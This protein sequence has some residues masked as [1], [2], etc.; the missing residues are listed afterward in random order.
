MNYMRFQEKYT[1]HCVPILKQELKRSNILDL[2]KI[3]K[4]VVN[5]GIGGHLKD[6]KYKGV[7]VSTLTR[8]TGQK[9]VEVKAKKSIANFKVRA[10]TPSGLKVT[11]RNKRMHDFVDKL[12]NVV[13]PRVPDFRGIPIS[14]IDKNGNFSFGF[15]EHLVF[16]EIQT[17]EVE[18]VHGLVVTLVTNSRT[19]KEGY[20]LFSTLG[21]PFDKTKKIN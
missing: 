10:G 16:P 14:C 8:I 5:V 15:K 13:W 19:Q 20:L 17:D 4:A 7:V 18:K 1:K 11:I 3:V 21:F 2:P 12:V 6:P 9:P